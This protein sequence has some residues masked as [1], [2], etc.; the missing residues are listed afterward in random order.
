[1]EI[2][3]GKPTGYQDGYDPARLATMPR[4][5]GRS[6]LGLH[7]PLPFV[8]EDVWRGYEFSWLTSTGMP[9][10]AMLELRAPADSVAMVES[11][12]MKLYLNGYAQTRFASDAAVLERLTADL[13]GAFGAPV[14]VRLLPLSVGAS[15]SAPRE[16]PGTTLDGLTLDDPVFEPEPALL[17][18]ESPER[19]VEESVYTDLFRSMCPVTGQ[20]DWASMLVRYAGPA[21]DHRGLLAYLVSYRCHQAFHETTVEQIFLDLKARCGCE[22]LLVIGYFLRRGGLDIN[23]VRADPGEAWADQ[24]LLRQ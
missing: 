20:P 23:P 10:V 11:K 6:A 22:R 16:P 8:G 14:R 7:G 18:L 15:A 5:A 2:P 24:R 13:Y 21:I 4:E 1:M 19:I 3:L 12:S 17:H 9:Q